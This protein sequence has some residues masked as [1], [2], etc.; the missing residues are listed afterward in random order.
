MNLLIPAQGFFYIRKLASG[1]HKT[2]LGSNRGLSSADS[3]SASSKGISG[4]VTLATQAQ[5]DPVWLL[6]AGAEL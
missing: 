1:T 6:M 5:L 4:E 3:M 2:A